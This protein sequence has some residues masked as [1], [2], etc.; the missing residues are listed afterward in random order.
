MIRKHK[1][2]LVIPCYNE[3]E[4]LKDTIARVPKEI[5][6]ILVV[7]NNSTDQTARV[8]KKLGARVVTE[9]QK[10]YGHALKKGI[11]SARGNIVVTIDGDGTY[12]IENV[13]LSVEYLLDESLDFVSCSRFPLRNRNS[14]HWQNLLGN[15]LVSWL[16]KVLFLREFKDGLSGMW[17]FKKSIFPKMKNLSSGWNLSEEIKIEAYLHPDIT[18]DEYRINYHPRFG[19]SNVW[20]LKVGIQNILYLFY[21]RFIKIRNE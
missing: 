6:E 17:V 19:I 21:L 10:G 14:M 3:Q 18:F 16:M 12:P 20:P 4:G 7:D 13:K 5:D 1:I 15:K 11:R 8:A 9:K 2:S